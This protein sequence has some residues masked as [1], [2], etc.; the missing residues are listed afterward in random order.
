LIVK[1]V[2]YVNHAQIRSWNQPVHCDSIM[3]QSYITRSRVAPKYFSSILCVK[4]SADDRGIHNASV[5]SVYVL[6]KF[7][8]S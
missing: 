3:T 8:T 1:P 2:S 5:L 4:I 6:A 7:D